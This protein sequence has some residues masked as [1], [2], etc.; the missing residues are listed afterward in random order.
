M[1]EVLA[2]WET[3]AAATAKDVS[4]VRQAVANPDAHWTI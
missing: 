4:R 3:A 2:T 1:L